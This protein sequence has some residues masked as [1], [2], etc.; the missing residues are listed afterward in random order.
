M[1]KNVEFAGAMRQNTDTEDTLD[2]DLI[3]DVVRSYEG[4]C[5]EIQN[6]WNNHMAQTYV[7]YEVGDDG[8]DGAYIKPYCSICC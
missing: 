3:G 6:E 5:E 2:A 7:D 4:D 1:T 8:A